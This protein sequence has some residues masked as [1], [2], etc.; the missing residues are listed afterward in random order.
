MYIHTYIMIS[1][2]LRF[3]LQKESSKHVKLYN[4]WLPISNVNF[5]AYWLNFY[6]GINLTNITKYN[7]NK[8]LSYSKNDTLLIISNA[9]LNVFS[10]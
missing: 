6:S 8:T 9:Q 3:F 10:R 1:E 5:H 4:R 7:L 2:F